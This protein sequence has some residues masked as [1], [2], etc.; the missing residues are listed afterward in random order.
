M[1]QPSGIGNKQGVVTYSNMG[2][3]WYGPTA[4]FLLP[5]SV[6]S[7]QAAYMAGLTSAPNTTSN[8]PQRAVAKYFDISPTRFAFPSTLGAMTIGRFGPNA[9]VFPVSSP[10]WRQNYGNVLIA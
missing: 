8:L 6:S 3:Y 1:L 4:N 7:M 2:V 10:S 5:Q 9:A